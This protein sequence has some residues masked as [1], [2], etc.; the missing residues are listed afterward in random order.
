MLYSSEGFGFRLFCVHD[1]AW[2]WVKASNLK[3][4]SGLV[5]RFNLAHGLIAALV[6]LLYSSEGLRFHL[7]VY[8][9]LPGGGSRLQT[10]RGLAA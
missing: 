7:F 2:W 5:V 4:P 3:R 9:I 10:L 8:M 1:P 6:R